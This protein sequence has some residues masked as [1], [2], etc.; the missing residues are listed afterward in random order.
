MRIKDDIKAKLEDF[1]DLCKSHK[2]KY[3]YAFG[4]STT[5][6]FDS[7]TSD[8]DLVVDG[9]IKGLDFFGL[10]EDVTNLFVKQV[11]LIHLSQI[12][13]GSHTYKEIMKGMILFERKR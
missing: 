13:K 4:S 9:G 8:I 5:D 6:S 10:L 11:D 3:L 7:Q 12:E 1:I 2:V